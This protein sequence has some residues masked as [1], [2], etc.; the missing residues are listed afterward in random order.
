MPE[1]R[2]S[3]QNQIFRSVVGTVG[4][5][6]EPDFG[7]RNQIKIFQHQLRVFKFSLN[8]IID[9]RLPR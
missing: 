6:E 7:L 3:N 9:P 2:E 8:I 1:T 4:L 5:L